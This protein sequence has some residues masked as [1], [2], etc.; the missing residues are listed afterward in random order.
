MDQELQKLE[1]V[2]NEIV[3]VL[4]EQSSVIL[5]IQ[6]WVSLMWYAM[7]VMLIIIVIL[8]SLVD[9]L[10]RKIKQTNDDYDLKQPL[11]GPDAEVDEV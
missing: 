11:L 1:N 2:T 10:D 6:Q 9:K 4:N 3:Q 8:I 7:V 5:D